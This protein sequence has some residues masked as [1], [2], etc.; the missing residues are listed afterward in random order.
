MHY[1][2]WLARRWDD[3][4]FP[5]SF[6]WFHTQR[7]W[8]DHILELREQ[9]APYEEAA[10]VTEDGE[11]LIAWWV[12]AE[13]MRGAV[14]LFHGNAGNISHRVD[15]ALMFRRLHYGTLLVDYR[16]YGRSSGAPTEEGTYRDARASWR[17]LTEV[18]GFGAGDIVLF[19]ESLGGAVAC[20]LAQEVAPRALVLASTFT[21]VPD[22]GARVYPFLPVR[23]LSRYRYDTRACLPHVGVPVLIMHSP[24]DEI[25]PFT[26]SE[27]LYAAAN[28]PKRF[29]ELAGG[30]NTGFVFTRPEWVEALARFLEEAEKA[31]A[32]A[33]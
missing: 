11:T 4:A 14:L 20:R 31:S 25:V 26:H 3:P 2:A 21:S 16:G 18:R 30:H 32:E 13:P 17:W 24:A 29:F 22:L 28:E 10:I 15:Y 7:Y 6:P 19:G 5:A 1:A 27:A 9:G 33:R 23:W 12:P 8:Q